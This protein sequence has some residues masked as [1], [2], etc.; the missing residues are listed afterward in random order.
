MESRT[1]RGLVFYGAAFIDDR[2]YGVSAAK[3]LENPLPAVILL[4]G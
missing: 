1:I 4:L 3:S 2:S